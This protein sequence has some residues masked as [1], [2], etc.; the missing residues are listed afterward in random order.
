VPGT[1]P[2]KEEK[3]GVASLPKTGGS[4]ETEAALGLMLLLAGF[5]LRRKS[6]SMG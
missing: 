3:P 2:T 4:L 6:A 5:G 1:P